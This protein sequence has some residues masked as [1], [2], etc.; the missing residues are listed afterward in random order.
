MPVNVSSGSISLA[1]TT[2][3]RPPGL[4]TFVCQ[5]SVAA[6]DGSKNVPP[7]RDASELP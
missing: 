7:N 1:V 3:R 5:T 4:C 2:S 6:C